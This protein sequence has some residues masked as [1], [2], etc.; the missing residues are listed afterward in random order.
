MTCIRGTA[1]MLYPHWL[2]C[3]VIKYRTYDDRDVRNAYYMTLDNAHLH[4]K[5]ATTLYCRALARALV[6]ATF[7]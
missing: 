6:I 3:T 2:G 7:I 4:N 1:A 5:D